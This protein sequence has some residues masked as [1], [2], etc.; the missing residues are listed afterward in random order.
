MSAITNVGKSNPANMKDLG[1]TDTHSHI[2]TCTHTLTKSYSHM[3]THT[4]ANTHTHTSH[5][6][7]PMHTLKLTYT[8]HMHT[9][10]HTLTYAHSLHTHT[11]G[12]HTGFFP[13]GRKTFFTSGGERVAAEFCSEIPFI[14]I[15][16]ILDF[17]GEGGRRGGFQPPPPPCMK[18]CTH[19][20]NTNEG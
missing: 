5:T 19:L 18:P 17:G 9:Y 8:C 10:T 3:H 20:L 11:S 7:V 6:L 14:I 12:L 1:H 4:H 15:I 2:L 13:W 16:K